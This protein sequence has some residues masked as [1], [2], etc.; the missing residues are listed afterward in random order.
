LQR[1]P[2]RPLA[3]GA[4]WL[5][6]HLTCQL[7]IVTGVPSCFQRILFGDAEVTLSDLGVQ[8][9]SLGI[10]HD[11][12]LG[13]VRMS[14]PCGVFESN[15]SRSRGINGFFGYGAGDTFE[16][17][18]HLKAEF[19]LGGGIT[20]YFKAEYDTGFQI[21]E[22]QGRLQATDE[23]GNEFE[24]CVYQTSGNWQR[25][26]DREQHCD[27]AISFSANS[28]GSTVTLAPKSTKSLTPFKDRAWCLQRLLQ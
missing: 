24:S 4:S 9:S 12:R 11:S 13:M 7:E 2:V 10:V 20:I 23:T 17:T 8:L 19:D 25:M 14:F 28:D 15:T 3:S 26:G 21:V 27:I 6:G 16:E 22:L 1:F 5:C 18:E